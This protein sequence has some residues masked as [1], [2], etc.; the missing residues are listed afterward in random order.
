MG[1]SVV[2][3]SCTHRKRVP[4]APELLA[5]SLP[6]GS[7]DEVAADW[8][9]RLTA[10]QPLMPARELYCGRGFSD[11]VATADSMGADLDIV[12]A[13][14]G[15]VH[16]NSLVPSYSLTLSNHS[17]D[18][19]AR[20]VSESFV[21]TDWWRRLTRPHRPSLA[22]IVR[23]H[24]FIIIALPETYL[25]LV[26]EDLLTLAEADLRGIR[27]IGPR[28][29]KRVP[30]RLCPQLLPYDERFDAIRPGTN[31]DF[32]QRCARHFTESIWPTL[33]SADA[34]AHAAAVRRIL[35]HRRPPPIVRRTQLTDTEIIT[36]IRRVG[37]RS[38]SAGLRILRDKYDAACEQAR[39]RRLFRAAQQVVR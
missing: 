27:L 10:V 3:T 38:A 21:P 5:R 26:A 31:A 9:A 33:P 14:L 36:I 22:T 12:S 11:A 39:F 28:S 16:E 4:P 15:I 32:A 25:A 19:L 7:V 37:P 29:G 13:G 2:I 35:E 18:G 24:S 8:Q 1:K 34:F 20:I 17:P 30:R 23:E 6:R